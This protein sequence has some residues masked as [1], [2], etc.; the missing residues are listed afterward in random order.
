MPKQYTTIVLKKSS[1]LIFIGI[2]LIISACEKNEINKEDNNCCNNN[3]SQMR[4][5]MKEEGYR[6]LETMPI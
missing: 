6:E 2:G 3:V 1:L 4:M 5:S